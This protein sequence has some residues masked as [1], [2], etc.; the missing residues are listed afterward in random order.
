MHTGLEL[1]TALAG[2]QAN[3]QQATAASLP[4]GVVIGNDLCKETLLG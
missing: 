2:C 4:M 3:N 1:K